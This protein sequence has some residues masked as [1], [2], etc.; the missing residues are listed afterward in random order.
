MV[1]ILVVKLEISTGYIGLPRESP[2]D[3]ARRPG[4]SRTKAYSSPTKPWNLGSLKVTIPK[5]EFKER[6]STRSSSQADSQKDVKGFLV[7]L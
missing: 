3:A 7:N 4:G 1:G 2:S 6:T 5:N